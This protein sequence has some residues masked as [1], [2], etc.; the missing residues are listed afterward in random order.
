VL[1]GLAVSYFA[2]INLTNYPPA[3]AYQGLRNQ[4]WVAAG[5]HHWADPCSRTVQTEQGRFETRLPTEQCFRM[6]SPERMRGVWIDEFERSR[7]LSGARDTSAADMGLG[8]TWLDV[9][10]NR[11]PGLFQD[12]PTMQ[13]RAFEVEFIGRK[14]SYGGRYAHLGA[15]DNYVVVDRLIS[16]RPLDVSRYSQRLEASR[17]QLQR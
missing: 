11:I 5:L 9:E 14:T 17:R 3:F 6:S 4:L 10:T 7:F 12:P 1:L 13:L 16:A 2:L 8:G 15:S